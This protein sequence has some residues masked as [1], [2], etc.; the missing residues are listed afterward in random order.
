MLFPLGKILTS[1]SYVIS[2][3]TAMCYVGSE[4]LTAV[5]K[6]SSI[7]WDLTPCIALKVNREWYAC[8]LLHAGLLL[9][10]LLTLK[11]EVKYYFETSVDF[12]RT[13][14]RCMPEEKAFR[15]SSLLV[16]SSWMQLSAV[17]AFHLLYW[18]V[19]TGNAIGFERGLRE[20][21]QRMYTWGYLLAGDTSQ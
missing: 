19:R 18:V 2:G 8:Y 17:Y 21:T 3:K 20:R 9:D 10:L 6:K 16:I 14:G 4:V 7:F 13:A 5:V 15:R 11:V 12:Q 1:H